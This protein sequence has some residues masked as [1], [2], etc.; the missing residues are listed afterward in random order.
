[1]DELVTHFEDMEMDARVE[2]LGEDIA[3]CAA[4]AAAQVRRDLETEA[5]RELLAAL[6]AKVGPL[7][8]VE[9]M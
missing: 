8:T 6:A 1:M 4:D 5:G 9:R 3:L 7:P 2:E